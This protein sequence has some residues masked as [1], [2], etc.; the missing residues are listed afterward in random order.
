MG[1]RGA[2]GGLRWDRYRS[3]SRA[4]GCGGM[5][6]GG[7]RGERSPYALTLAPGPPG[8]FLSRST[9]RIWYVV[10]RWIS[11]VRISGAGMPMEISPGLWPWFVLCEWKNISRQ[12][13]KELV[14][15]PAFWSAFSNLHPT[16]S[17]ARLRHR[18]HTDRA[19]VFPSTG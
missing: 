11:G 17:K 10:D 19:R 2:A 1:D 4:A 16:L 18:S 8:Q 6:P 15:V 12:A 13:R 14:C 5:R 3:L 9:A 7:A